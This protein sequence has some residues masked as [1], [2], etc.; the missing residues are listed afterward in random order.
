MRQIV[1]SGNDH[2]VR[3]H[4]GPEA[5][6]NLQRYMLGSYLRFRAADSDLIKW[7]SVVAHVYVSQ[8]R[9]VADIIDQAANN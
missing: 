3:P 5:P 1:H 8:P 4:D 9:S 2:R 6:R 7:A